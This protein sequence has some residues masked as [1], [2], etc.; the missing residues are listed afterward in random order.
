LRPPT[1][2]VASASSS[3][4]ALDVDAGGTTGALTDG[5]LVLRFLV[6]LDEASLSAGVVGET[7][8]RCDAA[9]VTD[10]LTTLEPSSTSMATRV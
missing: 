10:Y 7:C 2:V 5:L 4:V 8:I 3:S 9:A 6:G 1:G